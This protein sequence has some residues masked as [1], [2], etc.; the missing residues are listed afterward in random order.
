METGAEYEAGPYEAGQYEVELYESPS[1][2]SEEMEL[3]AELL[4]V[5]SEDELD[6]FIGKLIKRVGRCGHRGGRRACRS[7]CGSLSQISRPE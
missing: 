3:A 6:Q 5:M 4:E 2:E 7:W 1:Q